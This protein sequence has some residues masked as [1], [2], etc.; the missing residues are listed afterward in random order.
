MRCSLPMSSLV[1]RDSL[2]KVDR[3]FG[4]LIVVPTV[5]VVAIGIANGNTD[6]L[7]P[8]LL[9]LALGIMCMAGWK[10]VWILWALLA[11]FAAF[12][13]MQIPEAES[14]TE[15][16]VVSATKMLMLFYIVPGAWFLLR[17]IG[18]IK[19]R[20]TGIEDKASVEV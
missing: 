13:A 17:S 4:L 15:A 11:G 12:S 18:L 14:E 1:I 7:V 8:A 16:A 6:T 3:V 20:P 9:I 19:G 5:A 10:I 2:T